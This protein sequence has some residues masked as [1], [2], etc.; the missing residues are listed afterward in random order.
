MKRNKLIIKRKT[1][2]AR[3]IL[4][5]CLVFLFPVVS[6]WGPTMTQ[7]LE[8]ST[9]IAAWQVETVTPLQPFTSVQNVNEWKLEV[10]S[11]RIVKEP[12]I[13]ITFDDVGLD[14][15]TWTS[16]YPIMEQYGFKGVAFVT[17]KWA[18]NSADLAGL[19]TLVEN[20]WEIGSHGMTH[21]KLSQLSPDAL[22]YEVRDSKLFLETHLNTSV[23]CLGYPN[24]DVNATVQAIAEQYYEVAR[25]NSYWWHQSSTWNTT[26]NYLI[27]S[28]SITDINCQIN[29]PHAI[30]MAK[31]KNETTVLA[32]H[33]VIENHANNTITPTNFAWCMKTLNESNIKTTT[34]QTVPLTVTLHANIT[35]PDD[36]TITAKIQ[37]QNINETT[38]TNT[39]TFQLYPLETILIT[40]QVTAGN[41]EGTANIKLD[42][43]TTNENLTIS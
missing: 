9:I 25:T 17:A 13:I 15:S 43:T 3:I 28:I 31:T 39:T 4:V 23:T 16:A 27:P 38:L 6:V 22:L 7:S 10:H 34:F 30:E 21:K 1:A 26:R 35:K 37:N 11:N 33:K 2:R 40:I 14:N 41:M 32:F 18:N 19:T 8:G 42:F 12:A 36:T 5:T 29:M 20:R 24:S